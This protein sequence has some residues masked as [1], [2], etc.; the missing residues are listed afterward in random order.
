TGSM[1]SLPTSLDIRFA[2]NGFDQSFLME[3]VFGGDCS[4]CGPV[5]VWVA[6]P[7]KRSARFY[8]ALQA[9]KKAFA[10]TAGL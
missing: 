6:N 9:H 5:L 1:R 10:N 2:I 7:N 3:F 4:L 8:L